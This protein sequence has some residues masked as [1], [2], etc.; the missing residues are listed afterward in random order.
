MGHFPAHPAGSGDALGR[1]TWGRDLVGT[2]ALNP[3]QVD[4]RG[5]GRTVCPLLL[6]TS[7]Y[8]GLISCTAELA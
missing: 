8:G 3:D 6:L 2:Q 4:R 5:R 1:D 7:V